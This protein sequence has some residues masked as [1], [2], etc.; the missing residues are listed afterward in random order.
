VRRTWKERQMAFRDLPSAPTLCIRVN[1]SRRRREYPSPRSSPPR[2]EE[3]Y[4][5]TTDLNGAERAI[6]PPW[7]AIALERRRLP[8]GA[9]KKTGIPLPSGERLGEGDD[10]LCGV[11]R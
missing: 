5:N 1:V 8:Q 7:L 4:E 6:N 10:K 11:T 3:E 9:R 2:G